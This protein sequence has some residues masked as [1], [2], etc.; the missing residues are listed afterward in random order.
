MPWARGT[1]SLLSQSGHEES[2]EGLGTAN[3]AD[4]LEPQVAA[5]AF[6]MANAMVTALFMTRLRQDESPMIF[7]ADRSVKSSTSELLMRCWP[8]HIKLCCRFKP[9][10]VL[11]SGLSGLG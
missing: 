1:L 11:G 8:L 10:P 3:D 4:A 2:V 7:S 5:H 6:R 9:Y